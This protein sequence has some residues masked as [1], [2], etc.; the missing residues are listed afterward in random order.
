MAEIS[1]LQARLQAAG[2]EPREKCPCGREVIDPRRRGQRYVFCSF[3]CRRSWNSQLRRLRRAEQKGIELERT[4]DVCGD[5]IGGLRSDARFCSTRCRV[6][7][8]RYLSRHGRR[9]LFPTDEI[10]F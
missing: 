10:P 7:A 1:E 4:C 3:A 5:S 8:H 2:Y 6:T 9:R